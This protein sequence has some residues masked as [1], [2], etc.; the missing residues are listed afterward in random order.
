MDARCG[1][2]STLSANDVAGLFNPLIGFNNP[3]F[4]RS[5]R[6]DAGAVFLSAVFI[7]AVLFTGGAS[8]CEDL[9]RVFAQA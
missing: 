4:N 1:D 8:G 3:D 2:G 7:S 5:L 9:F 6:A